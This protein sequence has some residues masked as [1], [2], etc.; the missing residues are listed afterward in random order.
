MLSAKQAALHNFMSVYAHKAELAKE[1]ARRHRAIAKPLADMKARSE[2]AASGKAEEA[3]KQ[4]PK[5]RQKIEEPPKPKQEPPKPKEEP[6]E[7][8]EPPSPK[9]EPQQPEEAKETPVAQI[10]QNAGDILQVEDALLE[11]APRGVLTQSWATMPVQA[12]DVRNFIARVT[13]T[14]NLPDEV[15]NQL[16]L[17]CRAAHCALEEAE[18]A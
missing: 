1:T 6:K 14:N 16:V 8:E 12:G 18:E 11:L 2:R 4:P 10:E 7:L 15:R 13:A 5:K 3:A 17:A 9:E